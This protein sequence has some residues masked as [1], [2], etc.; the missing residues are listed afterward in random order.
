VT[1]MRTE[2]AARGAEW[3]SR[4]LQCIDESGLN[5][6]MTRL[7]GRA[8]PG[9]RVREGTPGQS[10]PQLTL[11]AALG[12]NGVSAPWILAGALDGRACEVSRRRVLGP[13]VRRGDRV[14]RDNLP[15]HKVSA[16]REAIEAR[17]ARVEYLPPYSPDLHPIEKCWAKVKTAVRT[18]KARTLEDLLEALAQALRAIAKQDV[19]AWFTHCGYSVHA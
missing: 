13:P 10:G 16:V 11:I 17:G 2:Y 14:G 8:T 15:V 4:K 18:A 3:V 19:I 6:G 5:L 7:Y 1:Q 9:E 12:L